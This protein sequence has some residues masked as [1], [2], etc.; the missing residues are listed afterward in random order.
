ML[1]LSRRGV[2]QT[3]RLMST[4]RIHDPAYSALVLESTLSL[5]IR[6]ALAY[7]LIRHFASKLFISTAVEGAKRGPSAT[8]QTVKDVSSLGS[9]PGIYFNTEQC[10]LTAF[11]SFK[12]DVLTIFSV[13]LWCCKIKAAHGKRERMSVCASVYVFWNIAEQMFAPALHTETERQ[14]MQRKKLLNTYFM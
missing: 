10:N 5:C 2:Y 9:S 1:H 14:K 3:S 11:I 13:A 12:K 8:L 4:Q 6:A 7:C